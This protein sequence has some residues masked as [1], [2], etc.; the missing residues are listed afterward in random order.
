MFD[1]LPYIKF[2]LSLANHIQG[3]WSNYIMYFRL[4]S[5]EEMNQLGPKQTKK[6]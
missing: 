5:P 3:I 6:E 4:Y 2:R 1:F